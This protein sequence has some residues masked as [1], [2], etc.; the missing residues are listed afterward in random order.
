M[1]DDKLQKGFSL[2]ELLIVVILIGILAAIAIPSLLRS[3]QAAT[4]ASA[5]SHIRSINSAQQV[6]LTSFSGVTAYGTLANLSAN[7]LLDSR[8]TND[9]TVISTY[10]YTITLSASPIGYCATAATSDVNSRSFAVSHAGAIYFLAGT[11]APNCTAA[12]GVISTGSPL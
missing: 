6:Y 9:P 1:K 12:T 2:V 11:T 5:I 10:T 4:E 7:N 8:F 3:R